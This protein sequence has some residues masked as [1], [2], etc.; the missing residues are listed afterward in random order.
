MTTFTNERNG[1]D[2]IHI[3]HLNLKKTLE[4]S[5][6]RLLGALSLVACLT[7]KDAIGGHLMGNPCV[8]LDGE[9]SPAMRASKAKFS[10][11]ATL[12]EASE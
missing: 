2:S 9:R 3:L 11:L 1:S 8:E 12:V 7:Y 6:C 10:L 5:D 4:A